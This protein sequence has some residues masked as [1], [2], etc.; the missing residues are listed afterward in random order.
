M[1]TVLKVIK[2]EI[3]TTQ[4]LPYAIYRATE[5]QAI[6]NVSV[7]HPTLIIVLQGKKHLCGTETIVC[8]AKDFLFLGNTHDV[9]L[10]NIPSNDEYIALL[11][12]FDPDD[13]GSLS[14]HNTAPLPYL[15]GQCD[16]ALETLI[17]GVNG[18]LLL[19][20]QK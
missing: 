16:S 1:D 18:I 19:S 15:S 9:Q 12:E 4:A 2:N 11:I 6:A 20:R 13:F 14:K 7:L 10:R 8:S 17:R 5:A 3:T